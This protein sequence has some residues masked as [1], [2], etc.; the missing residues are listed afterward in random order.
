M[1]K[2][3]GLG[4]GLGLGVGLGLG[5]GVGLGLRVGYTLLQSQRLGE[6]TTNGVELGS[7]PG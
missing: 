7:T 2:R 5:L 4:L 1:Y 3:Q 6:Y